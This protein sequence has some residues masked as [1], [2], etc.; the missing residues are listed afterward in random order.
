MSRLNQWALLFFVLAKLCGAAGV[1]L[2]FMG[3]EYL[4]LG[5]WFLGFALGS[6]FLSVALC[7]RQGSL[8]RSRFEREDTETTRLKDLRDKRK[9]LEMEVAELESKRSAAERF[10]T[11]RSS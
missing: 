6:I 1:C 11:S 8:D 10:V 2:G 3:Q 7:L 5:G 9:Q 4:Q